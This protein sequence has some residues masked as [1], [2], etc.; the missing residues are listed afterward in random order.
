ME[1][2][3]LQPLPPLK[4]SGQQP[5]QNHS[6]IKNL[7]YSSSRFDEDEND[8]FYSPKGSNGTG[9][10][11]TTFHYEPN[12]FENDTT[13]IGRGCCSTTSTTSSG[14]SYTPSGSESPVR[15]VSLSTSPPASM[16]PKA[17]SITKSPE[18][19]ALR[20][21]KDLSES[22]ESSPRVSNV[23]SSLDRISLSPGRMNM[24]DGHPQRPNQFISS[25]SS[26]SPTLSD[27]SSDHMVKSSKCVP[28]SV[29]PPPPPPPPPPVPPALHS[30][31]PRT[32]STKIAQQASM[33]PVLV[34]PSRPLKTPALISPVELPQ[35]KEGLEMNEETPKL[36]LKPLHWDKVRASSDREMVWDH[37]RS[38]SFK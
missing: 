35:S 28:V 8:Q 2:P 20:N 27:A 34:A 26:S 15:S 30:E 18:L 10:R 22:I 11:R 16:S 21:S 9:S 32:P 37:L 4:L 1:S 13:T 5:Q 14:S 29:A 38:S 3:D 31:S 36:K 19:V 12:N 17:L 24:S 6:Y 23:S 25:P 33:P 7:D